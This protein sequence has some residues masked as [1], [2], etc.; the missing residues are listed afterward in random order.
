MTKVLP[1]TVRAQIP[2][3]ISKVMIRQLDIRPK[4]TAIAQITM[5]IGK[6]V[7]FEFGE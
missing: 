4:Y 2:I 5:L 1:T 6:P 7:G 3:N